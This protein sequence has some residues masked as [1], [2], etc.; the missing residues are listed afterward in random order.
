MADI[1]VFTSPAMANWQRWGAGS[2]QRMNLYWDRIIRADPT[3]Q[4]VYL[5][6]E[7]V[8]G[9]ERVVRFA[10]APIRTVSS[11]DGQVYEYQQGL[12]EEP[13]LDHVLDL[14]SNAASAR[15]LSFIVPARLIGASEI[16]LRGGMLAGV[17]EVSLQVAG[18]DYELRYVLLRGDMT[19]GI[20][21]G[22]DG[23][24]VQVQLEDPRTTQ[25]LLVPSVAVDTA[26]WPLAL[27]A[28]IGCRYPMVVNG[29]PKV[30]CERVL[31]DFGVSGL[32]YLA[33]SPPTGLQ[34]DAV[35]VNGEV[36]AGGYAPWTEVTG[37]DAKGMACKLVDFSGSAGPWEETDSVY[38]D[39]S[40][41]SGVRAMSLVQVVRW[42]LEGFTSL[43][44]F[45]LNPD[46]FGFADVAMPGYP[47]KVLINASGDSAISVQDFVENTLLS[48]FP[49]LFLSYQGQ[50][51]GP[52]V[53]DRRTL[54]DAG[55]VH[56]TLFGRQLPLLER[57]TW[58]QE[59][60]KA[61]IFNIYE[62]RYGFNAQDNSYTGHVERTPEN[63]AACRL[64]E[65]MIKGKR[66]ATPLASPFI[67]S[68]ALANYVIDWLV[69]HRALPA[70]YVEWSCVASAVLRYRLG[71]NVKYVDPDIAAFNGVKA[72]ITRLCYS[73]GEPIMGLTVWHPAWDTLL[74]GQVS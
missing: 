23:E 8:F 32:R 70:Y 38:A 73:R 67:H 57:R 65:R 63:S 53:V 54:P 55:N 24:G 41:A 18:G 29:Y 69:A 50:G 19:G 48:S 5:T 30:P 43:G 71:M 64:S 14:G 21:F 37:A 7:L 58:P 56:A 62:L 13:D 61:S 72:T 52:V 47:P 26:R 39:V 2:R 42:L 22:A 74:L 25:S 40:L 3:L 68:E 6:V 17:G 45:G 4:S 20:S 27:E 59:T 33:C 44:R 51:L 49:M 10:R 12:M 1:L 31:N 46:L 16:L 60:E 11:L 28:A 36:A 15:S 35:Y 66:A 34:V 9:E